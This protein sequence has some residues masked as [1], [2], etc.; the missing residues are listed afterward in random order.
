M[1]EIRLFDYQQEMLENITEVF[2]AAVFDSVLYKEKKGECG[3]FGDGADAY[4]D[5]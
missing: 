5:W 1:K 4:G 3:E 2:S